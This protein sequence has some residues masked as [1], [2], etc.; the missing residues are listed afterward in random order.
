MGFLLGFRVSQG[1]L[2]FGGLSYAFMACC[3]VL[4]VHSRVLEAFRACCLS[5]ESSGWPSS[6]RFGEKDPK[7]PIPLN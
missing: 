7:S 2:G 6:R 4:S 1:L 3:W 5:V